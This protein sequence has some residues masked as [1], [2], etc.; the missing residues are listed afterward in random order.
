MSRTEG[1]DSVLPTDEPTRS[2]AGAK[3][4]WTAIRRVGRGL[5]AIGA[6]SIPSGSGSAHGRH[7]QSVAAYWRDRGSI[8]H[9]T[10]V[11]IEQIGPQLA[12]KMHVGDMDNYYLNLGV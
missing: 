6:D 3:R 11:R 10:C 9:G 8:S 5:R 12:G 1:Q 4:G 7:R 2:G